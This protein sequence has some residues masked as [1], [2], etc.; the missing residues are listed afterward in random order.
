MQQEDFLKSSFTGQ[1][2]LFDIQQLTAVYQATTD[3]VSKVTAEVNFMSILRKNMQY[4]ALIFSIGNTIKMTIIYF[5]HD[6][7][8]HFCHNMTNYN[9]QC[10]TIW[11][12]HTK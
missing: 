7:Q 10:H 5:M 8:I 4:L 9:S 2:S 12:P 3:F 11:L 6:Q 1:I